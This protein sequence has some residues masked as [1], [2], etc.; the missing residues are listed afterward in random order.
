VS[1]SLQEIIDKLWIA[2][3]YAEWSPKTDVIALSDIKRWM[4]STDIEI[5]GF[6]RAL[7]GDRRF[8]IE[9]PLPLDDYIK[10]Q[11][12]YYERCLRENPDGEWSDSNYTAGGNLVNIFAHLWR[13]S[14]VP[15]PILDDLKMWIGRLYIEGDTSTRTCIVHATLE[16]LFEQEQIREFFSDWHDDEVLAVAHEEASEWYK[17]GGRSSFGKPR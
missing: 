9:P 4:S 11:K 15:R 16:H 1:E 13:D 8:R 14:S 3:E 7:L 12:H 10:F 17:G 2:P 6:A 5:L